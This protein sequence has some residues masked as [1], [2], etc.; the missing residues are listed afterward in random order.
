MVRRIAACFLAL[1]FSTSL[2]A[3][4]SLP[5]AAA[6]AP[7]LL[8]IQAKTTSSGITINKLKTIKVSKKTG[9][10]TIKPSVKTSGK[11]K[12]DSSKLT[13]RRGTKTVAKNVSAASLKPG[14][15]SVTTTAK[16][17]TWADKPTGKKVKK[18]T[19][20]SDGSKLV[21]MDCQV[22]DVETH[23]LEGFEVELM[24]LECTGNFDGVYEARAGYF[25]YTEENIWMDWAGTNLWGDSFPEAPLVRPI[26]GAKF[27]TNVY[28]LERKVY[29]TK[30]VAETKKVWSKVKTKTYKQTLTVKK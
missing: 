4:S 19:L 18:R 23:F 6:P 8:S 17:R 12:L 26:V 25:P 24:F 2:V 5:A 1:I 9:K 30:S 22:A 29:K 28:P 16:Y 13:V 11:T 20:V 21:R 15:Y 10:A 3:A 7:S 14:K 27:T